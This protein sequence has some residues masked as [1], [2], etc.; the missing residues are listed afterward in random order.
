MCAFATGEFMVAWKPLMPIGLC[1]GLSKHAFK[2]Y[3][4]IPLKS[5]FQDESDGLVFVKCYAHFID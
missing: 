4:Y 3:I 5:S 2:K 1:A